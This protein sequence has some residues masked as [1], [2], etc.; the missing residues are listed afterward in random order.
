MRFRLSLREAHDA[1]RELSIGFIGRTAVDVWLQDFGVSAAQH[2]DET[3]AQLDVV[4][5]ILLLEM[6]DDS[7]DL[8]EQPALICDR[9]TVAADNSILYAAQCLDE[10]KGAL[11]R[12]CIRFGLTRIRGDRVARMELG[13]RFGKAEF[14]HQ[15]VKCTGRDA[16]K[17]QKCGSD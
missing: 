10:I 3:G 8:R 11:P 12:L 15:I 17:Q 16:G 4:V 5:P 2:V 7:G 13:Q 9:L 14:G 6:P 1:A